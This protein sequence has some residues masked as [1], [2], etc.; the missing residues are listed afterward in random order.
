L[1]EALAP[2]RDADPTGY[3]SP[4]THLL[5]DPDLA[6]VRDEAAL[7]KLPEKERGLWREY[8]DEVRGAKTRSR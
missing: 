7:S 6:G 3:P 4:L 1:R 5:R 8:W 2:Y